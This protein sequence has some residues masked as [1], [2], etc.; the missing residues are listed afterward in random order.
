VIGVG[1]A[2]QHQHRDDRDLVGLNGMLSSFRPST[3]LDGSVRRPENMALV[4]MDASALGFILFGLF[5]YC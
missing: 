2:D 5:D 4:A 3:R 1:E